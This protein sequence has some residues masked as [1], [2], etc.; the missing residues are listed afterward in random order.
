MLLDHE[1]VG[2]T[3]DVH[4]VAAASVEELGEIE[5]ANQLVGE[6]A[7]RDRAEECLVEKRVEFRGVERP[8]NLEPQRLARTKI[9][10]DGEPR[11]CDEYAV[12]RITIRTSSRYR[13]CR[14]D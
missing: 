3:P 8:D 13:C 14:W 4:A 7:D 10:A 1:A 12:S 6:I 2:A 11:D 5:G 9:P